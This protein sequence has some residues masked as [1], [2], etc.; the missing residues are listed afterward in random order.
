MKAKIIF[1]VLMLNACI[2][3]AQTFSEK[4]TRELTFDKISANNTVVVA[5]ING[6]VKVMGYDGDKILLTV[7]KIITAKT[8][9]RLEKGK[10]D[11][12]L[13]VINDIDT[14]IFYMDGT[15]NRFEK[16]RNRNARH[17]SWGYVGNNGDNKSCVDEYG[18]EMNFIVRVPQ[19]VHVT[20]STI[21]DGDI[22]VENV[23]G[24]VSADNINGAIKLANL[25]QAATASTING[26][27]DV[28][29]L[30]NPDKD[31]RFY[32][33]NGDINANFQKG[34]SASMSFESYNGSFYTNIASLQ[35]LPTR[36]EKTSNENGIKYKLTGN[37]YQIG[38]DGV[39]LD[40]ETFNGN[41][42]LKEKTN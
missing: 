11:V 12:K 35:S 36:L 33:L 22:V 32:T 38:K 19:K 3:M 8:P 42:Y 31:C 39:F 15:C 37:R 17:S 2:C 5:N 27:V 25:T 9:E 14:I 24:K 16:H 20:V 34:L 26:N 18:Y 21:N 30:N 1:S 7:E 28:A 40:F 23:H 6:G 41:V 13:G 4:I 10:A 29:Y